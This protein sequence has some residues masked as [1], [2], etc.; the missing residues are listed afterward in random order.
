M[1]APLGQILH[2][3][4]GQTCSTCSKEGSVDAKASIRFGQHLKDQ[5]SLNLWNRSMN[6]HLANGPKLRRQTTAAKQP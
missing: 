4:G 2:S 5:G 3:S 6:G 1:M